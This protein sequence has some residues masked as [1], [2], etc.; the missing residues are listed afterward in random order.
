MRR[1]TLF[2]L[3]SLS[4]LSQTKPE[5][6]FIQQSS[7]LAGIDEY[8]VAVCNRSPSPFSV[9]PVDVR[10]YAFQAGIAAA[11]HASVVKAIATAN[12][13]SPF[14]YAS[15]AT[16]VGTWATTV[17]VSLDRTNDEGE[18]TGPIKIN[19]RV[20]ALL[21][22][23]AAFLSFA[24]YLIDRERRPVALPDNLLPVLPFTIPAGLCQSYAFFGV[25]K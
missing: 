15:L 2:L 16:E 8:E 25:A 10:V 17:V 5:I 13:R 24:R 21:P 4:C 23:G 14:Y 12:R 19:S 3:V 18:Q 6:T 11:S 7:S 9:D 20:K 22:V 1:F